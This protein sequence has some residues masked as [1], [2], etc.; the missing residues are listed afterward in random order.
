MSALRYRLSNLAMAGT[1][2]TSIADKMH[3]CKIMEQSV[4]RYRI[5]V[6]FGDGCN[7]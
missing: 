2:A 5:V 3:Y 7:K 4:L 6:L 1:S